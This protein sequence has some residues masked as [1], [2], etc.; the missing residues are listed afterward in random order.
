VKQKAS[1]NSFWSSLIV[2]EL[3]RQGCNYFCI[4]PGS[5]S[6]PLTVSVAQNPKANSNIFYDERGAA[7][8][9]LGYARAT[10]NP[11]VLICTSGTAAA[12][13][14]PAI[15]EAYQDSVPLIVFTADRPS[16]LRDTGAKQ[17]VD[18]VKMFGDYVNWYFELP[19]PDVNI[20]PQFVLTTIDQAYYKSIHSPKGPVH[21]NCMF[22][23]PFFSENKISINDIVEK[24]QISRKPFTT[25]QV[26]KTNILPD[27]KLI[28]K[29]NTSKRG[30]IIAG[31]MDNHSDS[32]AVLKFAEELKWPVFADITSGLRIGTESELIIEHFDLALLSDSF[33]N[34]I[35][36]E[37]II[38]FGKRFVSKRLLSYLN[39]LKPENYLVI[40]ESPNRLDPA[41]LVSDRIIS[42]ICQFCKSMIPNIKTNVNNNWTEKILSANAKIKNLVDEEVAN[43][44]LSEI[45]TAREISK[46]FPENSGMYLASSMPIRDMDMFATKR[47][48][49]IKIAS[50]RGACGIDGTIASAIGFAEGLKSAVTLVIGDLAIIHDLN[51]LHQLASCEYPIFIVLLNNS[52]GGIFSFLPIANQKNV[53][54]KYFVTPHSLTFKSAADLFKLKY[55]NPLSS[56]E[57]IKNY[58]SAIED[59]KSTIV[60]IT[61]IRDENFYLHKNFYNKV[62]ELLEK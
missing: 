31:K 13:Y 45:S 1:L 17:T 54:E 7:F 16:E 11:A 43:N 50:N 29:I 51:S 46:N 35:K 57:F 55:Y 14:Y 4:S 6:T 3:I 25:Y 27:S 53:F 2:E 12:N 40:D 22:R 23:E 8:H 47:Q 42:N 61:L 36:P 39:E 52:G 38:Q 44:N 30:V 37:M 5:R 9:A 28:E 41:H 59:K 58:Q 34:T 19:T 60:E 20:L 32:E 56:T 24:W 15:I 26:A 49:N 21:I 18:Q 48:S 62:V 10:G 33:S